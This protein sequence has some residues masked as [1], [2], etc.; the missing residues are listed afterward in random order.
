M[1]QYW[2]S[3]SRVVSRGLAFE[4]QLTSFLEAYFPVGLPNLQ[5]S[6]RDEQAYP[7]LTPLP[8]GCVAGTVTPGIWGRQHGGVRARGEFR[9]SKRNFLS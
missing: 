1:V 7:A 6:S 8:I 2:F 5:I 3:D 4:L 9:Q